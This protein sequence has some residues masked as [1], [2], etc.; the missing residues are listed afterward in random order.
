MREDKQPWCQSPELWQGRRAAPGCG[1]P[2][3]QSTPPIS[4]RSESAD[5]YHHV[6]I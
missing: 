2:S 1:A 3:F 4:L 6:S 5:I